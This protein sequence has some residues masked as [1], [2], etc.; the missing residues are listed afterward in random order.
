[1]NQAIF[2]QKNF[3]LLF[4]HFRF[5]YFAKCQSKATQPLL[6]LT[7]HKIQELEPKDQYFVKIPT[8]VIGIVNK[9]NVESATANNAMKIFLAVRI[10][11][12]IQY[13]IIDLILTLKNIYNKIKKLN[14]MNYS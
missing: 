9:H 6:N 4:L 12:M 3:Y 13:Q 1:M 11:E 14:E 8:K 7:L 10:P 2:K 5:L